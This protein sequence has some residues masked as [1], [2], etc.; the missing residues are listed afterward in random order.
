MM[1][2]KF[3]ILSIG[4][5]LSMRA[6]F[7]ASSP[8]G[9]IDFNHDVRPILSDNC[10][11]CH[12]PD[13]A[14][15]KAKLRLDLREHALLPAKSGGIAI[16]P[17]QPA[18][19]EL[20]L[21]ITDAEDAMPP[22]ETGKKLKPAEIETLRRWSGGGGVY[23]PHWAFVAPVAV[24]ERGGAGSPSRPEFKGSRPGTQAAS[25]KQPHHPEHP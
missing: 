25:E 22:A 11:K 8:T 7:G 15:R 24:R 18:K 19:S 3:W 6:G 17:G 21:R 12:G 4:I 9:T 1:Q 2:S 20:I 13:E 23:A 14:A 10:F 16:V 5:C